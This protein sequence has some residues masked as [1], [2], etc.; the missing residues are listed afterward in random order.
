MAPTN[1]NQ[2]AMTGALRGPA[3]AVQDP[4]MPAFWAVCFLIRDSAYLQGNASIDANGYCL[5]VDKL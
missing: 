2:I 3:G 1:D 5:L 4:L